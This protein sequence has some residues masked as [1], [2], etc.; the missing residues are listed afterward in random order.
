MTRWKF[1]NSL[2]L[3]LLILEKLTVA[4]SSFSLSEISKIVDAPKT[5]IFRLLKTLC[6]LDYLKYDIQNRKY[7]LG[8][9]VIFLDHLFLQNLEIREIARPYLERLSQEWDKGVNLL[10]LDKVEMVYVDRAKVHNIRDLNVNVGR[11]ISLHNTA[12]G[13]AVLAYLDKEKLLKIISEIEKDPKISLQI[14]KNGNKLLRV[15]H[16]VR[17]NGFAIC[18]EEHTRGVRAIAVPIF[19]PEGVNYAINMVVASE[20]VSIGELR[21]EYG[22]N[23]IKAG[24]EVSKAMGYYGRT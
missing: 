2:S 13:R 16:E 23:L 12:A 4:K 9:K 6:E 3:G 14:G 17:A 8:V 10:M 15:L 7:S 22:P 24:N 18:D 21:K 11:R 5:T 20:L 19:T 1:V